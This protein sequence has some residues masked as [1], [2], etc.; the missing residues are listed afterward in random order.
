M[1]FHEFGNPKNQK[2]M[3]IHGV[4]TPWQIWKPQI[5]YFK[6]NYFVI[7]P[8]L[9]GHIE[10]C[11]SEFLSLEKEA[12]VIEK[13]YIEKY[14]REIFAVCGLS[15]GGAISYVLFKNKNLI[16]K[17]LVL[18]GAP[19][20][21]FGKLLTK[22]MTKNYIEIIHKSHQRD[23]KT[24]DNFGKVFLPL[25]YLDDYLKIADTM[26]DETIKNIMNSVNENRFDSSVSFDDTHLLYIHGTKINE[27]AS[28]K[29]ARLISKYYPDTDIV[30]CKGYMHCYKAIYEPDDWINIVDNFFKNNDKK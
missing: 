6:R 4:L 19:L 2:I 9:D 13:Y 25:K 22:V 29:S 15:M 18:D 3:L 17:N 8:A 21:P 24:L 11:K 5:E 16:I 7:V 26:S 20:V 28:K 23:T 14:G 27:V 12:E 1:K 10:E 30:C